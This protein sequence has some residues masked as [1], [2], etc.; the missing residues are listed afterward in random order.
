MRYYLLK[1]DFRPRALGKPN[2]R[3]FGKRLKESHFY[4]AEVISRFD[5]VAVQEVNELPEWERIMYILGPDWDY[6]AT[7]V[8]DRA[9]GGNGERLTFAFDKRK[10]WFQNVAGEIVLPASMLISRVEG[11][12]EDESGKERKILEGKQFHRTPYFASFQSGWLKFDIC[13]VH[14]YYGAASG[15]KLRERVEEIGT[16]ARYLGKRADKALAED[17][18]T[19]L[20]G[21]F[22]IVRPDHETMQALLTEGFKVPKALSAPTNID[23]TKFYDQIAFK[24]KPEVI[25]YVEKQSPDPKKRNAGVFEIFE[26]VYR[27]DQL[28]QFAEA[29]KKT[30][31][32]KKQATESD[33]RDYYLT[34][35]TYQFSDHKPLWVRLDSNDADGY[36]ERLKEGT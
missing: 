14:I 35:R 6:I 34:W 24:T 11:L 25:E 26:S 7:D 8:T 1:N 28:D 32:G 23:R 33:L 31:N 16:V 10:V 36:L 21:D 15:E 30:S 22:N 29:A 17:K 20:L 27:E 19:L 12:A 4:I 5:F 2:R 18:A 9:L 3:G 13:T